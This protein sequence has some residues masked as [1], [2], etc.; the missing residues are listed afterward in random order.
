[1]ARVRIL[2]SLGVIAALTAGCAGPNETAGTLGGTVLGGVLGS[3]VGAGTGNVAATLTGAAVGGFLG[4]QIGRSLDQTSQQRATAA[5]FQ[6]LEYGVAGAPV[7]WR[8]QAYYGTVV[9]GPFYSTAGYQRCREYT[10]TVYVDG[11]PQTA[12]GVACRNEDG[13]WIPIR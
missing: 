7:A 13:N 4:N 2:I 1:M 8:E 6:A 9:P 11:Q 10:H 5:Q 12:R 3:A